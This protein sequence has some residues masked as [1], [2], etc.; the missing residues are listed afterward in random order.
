MIKDGVLAGI[1]IT[2]GGAGYTSAPAVT[3][4]GGG[5]SGAEAKA[6]I[7]P[8]APAS[9]ALVTETGR[10]Y[11]VGENR[12]AVF[13]LEKEGEHIRHLPMG[14]LKI[15]VPPTLGRDGSLYLI[16]SGYGYIYG[17]NPNLEELWRYPSG[18]GSQEA[19][20]IT[21]FL[22]GPARQEYGYA[23]RGTDNKNE[24]VRI[25]T[26]YGGAEGRQFESRFTDFHRPLVVRGQKEDKVFLAVYSVEDGL[27]GCYSG[28]EKPWQKSGPVS[29]PNNDRRGNKIFVVQS[30]RFRAYDS[31]NGIELCSA[32]AKAPLAA[33]SNLVIDGEERLY[34][35][36]NGMLYGYTGDCRPFLSQAITGLPEKLE[37]LFG[38]DGTLYAKAENQSLYAL[39]PKAPDLNL[40][41]SMVG[42]DTIYNGGKIRVPGD[43][44]IPGGTEVVLRARE[45][46]S[47]GAGFTVKKGGSLS[48]G[49]GY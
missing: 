5:G 42:T 17:I 15:S 27:L 38:P 23:A 37:L 46:I 9:H 49:T 22:L 4:S 41:R 47:F 19:K 8:D 28:C 20:K 11:S 21:P 26:G 7:G 1:V 6:V 45:E 32:G 40:D 30:G 36:N 31:R 13:D 14:D 24:F 10:L 25:N 43:V 16:P 48:C 34:F 2:D 35:W 39:N 33:T 29:A 44:E 12:I 18:P 3:I